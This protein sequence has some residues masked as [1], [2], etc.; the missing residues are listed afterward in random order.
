MTERKIKETS[1][2][3]YVSKDIAIIIPTRNR[4]EEVRRLLK[5]I[6]ELDCEIGRI[7]IVASGQD[8][9]KVVMKFKNILPVEYYSSERGQIR[10]RNHGISLLGDSTKLVATMDDDTTFKKT[11]VTEIIKF[12][13]SV[14][15]ETAGVGF[16]IVNYP[17]HRHT[18]IRSIFGVSVPEPGRVLKSGF[19][20]PITNIM[21]NIRTEWLNGGTTVWR[22]DILKKYEHREIRSKWAVCEDLIYSYPIGKK[23]PMYICSNAC[24]E[25]EDV[26]LRNPV[27]NVYKMRGINLVLWQFYFV[28]SNKEM[29]VTLFVYRIILQTLISLIKWSFHKD[30]SRFF[31]AS[32]LLKGLFMVLGYIIKRGDLLDLIELKT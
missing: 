22:Q 13:N 26:V 3:Y 14:E 21:K 28:S 10:Q 23:Y 20:T 24:V 6:Y 18:W 32:G 15:P 25:I 27:N 5:S 29:S 7:I 30:L 16:N 9:Q 31:F 11:A 8:I 2:G 1:S 12:W 4:P 17:S 19:N